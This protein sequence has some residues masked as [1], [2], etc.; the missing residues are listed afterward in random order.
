MNHDTNKLSAAI[1]SAIAELD[2]NCQ[3]ERI[4]KAMAIVHEAFLL[5]TKGSSITADIL[6]RKARQISKEQHDL[7]F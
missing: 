1:K 5:H 2:L 6:L 3:D 7:N 4:T